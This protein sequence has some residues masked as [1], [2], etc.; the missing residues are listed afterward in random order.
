MILSRETILSL[1]LDGH[2]GIDP[3]DEGLFKE[4]SYTFT[5]GNTLFLLPPDEPIDLRIG[6]PEPTVVTIDDDGFQLQPDAFIIA[7]TNE[8]IRLPLGIACMLSTPSTNA[9]IGLDPLQTSIFCEP[10]SDNPIRL[11]LRN[12]GTSPIILYPG[13]P[14]VKGIFMRVE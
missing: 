9:Q 13:M 8:N 1:V 14:I 4:A 2:I 3:F 5:L 10:L 6:E 7:V 12:N 11:E